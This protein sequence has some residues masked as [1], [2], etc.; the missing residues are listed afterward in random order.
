MFNGLFE[1][2]LMTFKT[3]TLTKDTVS[4]GTPLHTTV[5]ITYEII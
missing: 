1:G 2:L 4:P 5:K 3:Q